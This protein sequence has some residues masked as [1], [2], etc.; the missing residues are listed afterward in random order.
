L[1]EGGCLPNDLLL[2]SS[3]N[4]NFQ[5]TT[6]SAAN[7]FLCRNT[8]W[9]LPPSMRDVLTTNK[10]NLMGQKSFLEYLNI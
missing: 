2:S 8:K 10:G 7:E 1:D 3:N 4:E 9:S 5:N 6:N